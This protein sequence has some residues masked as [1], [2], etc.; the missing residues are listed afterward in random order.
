MNTEDSKK[1]ELILGSGNSIN[2]VSSKLI[3]T[4][5]LLVLFGPGGNTHELNIRIE[6]DLSK[7]P[8]EY[9]QAFLNMFTAKYLGRVTYVEDVL[10]EHENP[11]RKWYEF[12]KVI[13][14]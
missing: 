4:T 13:K 6:A 9:H 3:T 8:E 12:W 7:L 1:T 5:D 2:V 10:S 11:K 14:I